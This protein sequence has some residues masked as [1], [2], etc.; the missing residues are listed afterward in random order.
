MTEKIPDYEPVVILPSQG[1]QAKQANS[2]RYMD[3]IRANPIKSLTVGLG[4]VALLRIVAPQAPQAIRNVANGLSKIVSAAEA[5]ALGPK[6]LGDGTSMYGGFRFKEV[7][8]YGDRLEPLVDEMN[9]YDAFGLDNTFIIFYC[10]YLNLSWW[11]L[12]SSLPQLSVDQ[13]TNL[14]II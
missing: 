8:E 10:C 14:N 6:K 1:G 2:N 5:V 3:F 13:L 7:V 12:Y 4:L 11:I 9:T